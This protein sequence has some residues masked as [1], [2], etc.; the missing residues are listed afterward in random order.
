MEIR[1]FVNQRTDWLAAFQTAL[2]AQGH[3]L[4]LT[5]TLSMDH[6]LPLSPN[7]MA[8]YFGNS[9][10]QPSA[11]EMGALETY[12]KEGH[13][14]LPV[15]ERP[16]LA[17]QDLPES[18]KSINAFLLSR[19]SSSGWPAALVDEVLAY[20]WLRRRARRMFISY[21]RADS[22][23]LAHQLHDHFM[24]LGFDVFLDDCSIERGANFQR[25]LMWWLNDADMVLLL[26]SPQLTT[27]KWVMEEVEF[28][29]N[30]TIGLLGV[31]WP[32]SRYASTGQT[33][34]VI[35]NT[36][37]PDQHY[38]LKDGDLQG[39]ETRPREQTL[40]KDALDELTTAVNR[41]RAQAIRQRLVNL[42]PYAQDE[43]SPQFDVRPQPRL[44]DLQLVDRQTLEVVF[45]RVLPFRPTLDTVF[46]LHNE[47]VDLVPPPSAVGCYY[48]END[49][50]DVRIRALHWMLDVERPK[51]R[52]SRH[53][54]WAYMGSGS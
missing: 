3:A 9:A 1:V 47:A 45:A 53:L 23:A 20:T 6:T 10:S 16:E 48:A 4:Q 29:N 34:P 51:L 35:A 2:H 13:T 12:L 8:V 24:R 36:L 49:P 33:E 32:E 11:A 50:T 30:A 46:A 26:V 27:S 31:R 41:R 39:D 17:G 42:L 44:G 40:G 7:G 37:F 43:L 14:V 22:E 19:Y 18:L 15:I 54:L 38:R 52:P 28:A 5:L 21:R 25:E